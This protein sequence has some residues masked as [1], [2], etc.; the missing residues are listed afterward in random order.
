M[1][2]R[3]LVVIGASAG[4][5]EALLE[6]TRTLPADFSAAILI[7]W[8][9]PSVG[10]GMLP[11]MLER[12]S[13]LPAHNAVDHEELCPGQIYVA[14]V[15]HH[16]LVERGHVRVTKG[17]KENR[18]R[19]A[20][21]PLFRSAAYTYGR[22]AIGIVL[23]GALSDG[24]L[25]LWAIKDRGGVAVVQDPNDAIVAGMPTSALE[26][27]NV[28]YRL[29]AFE[30]GALLQ[31]LTTEELEPDQAAQPS[32]RLGINVKYAKQECS[33]KAKCWKWDRSLSLRVRNVTVRCGRCTRGTFCA[34]A[35]AQDMRILPIRCWKIWENPLRRWSGR[36]RAGFKRAQS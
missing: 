25:G 36:R 15:D 31:R 18:F 11:R 34:F 35:V 26:N 8:H 1:A 3:E 27:V 12:T 20:I 33:R 7:V 19:P 21:D 29:P 24:T 10:I 6:L 5:R 22:Q 4:G 17:P 16:L 9:M 28:D 2:T 13:P 14:P 30:M 32:E 23:S